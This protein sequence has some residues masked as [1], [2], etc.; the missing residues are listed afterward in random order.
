MTSE[1]YERILAGVEAWTAFYRANPHRFA[2]DY[3]NLHLKLFQKI[4]LFLMN[5][6]DYFC[7]IAARGCLASPHSNMRAISG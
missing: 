3:L 5:I 6:S 2:K 7:Y 1:R 4:L